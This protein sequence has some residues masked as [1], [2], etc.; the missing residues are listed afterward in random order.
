MP[1]IS[2]PSPSLLSHF[3]S[4]STLQVSAKAKLLWRQCIRR[5]LHVVTAP[6]DPPPSLL[7][8]RIDGNPSINRLDHSFKLIR[9]GFLPLHFLLALTVR[10]T[11]VANPIYS[12]EHSLEAVSPAEESRARKAV[13]VCHTGAIS[14]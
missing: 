7:Y 6:T 14:R 9:L 12:R 3:C 8:S 10:Q 11:A 1:Y 13:E 4:L 2:Y 5:L